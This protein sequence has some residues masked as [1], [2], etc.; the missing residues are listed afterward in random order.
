MTQTLRTTHGMMMGVP[1]VITVALSAT[2]NVDVGRSRTRK[3]ALGNGSSKIDGSPL[4]VM[5]VVRTMTL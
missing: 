4:E 3:D 5:E 1:F 2:S